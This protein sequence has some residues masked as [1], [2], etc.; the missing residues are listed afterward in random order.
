MGVEAWYY[1]VP[2]RE[3]IQEALDSLREREFR[4]GRHFPAMMDL[5]VS[6]QDAPPGPGAQHASIVAAREEAAE[7]GTKSIL[8]FR[9]FYG[10]IDPNLLAAI[11]LRESDFRNIPQYRKGHGR[12][13][14]QID[15]RAHPDVTAVQAFNIGYAANYAAG[16]I[17]V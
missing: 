5:T 2:Y 14:F 10:N 15:L 1:L 6:L 12:G 9:E 7:D 13:V 3:N 11:A 16:F 8:D 4:A 17:G